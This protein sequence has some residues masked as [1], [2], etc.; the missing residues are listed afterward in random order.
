MFLV[1]EV[2][3]VTGGDDPSSGGKTMSEKAC[4][5]LTRNFN[6]ILSTFAIIK[7][8]ELWDCSGDLK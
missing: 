3:V 5:Q 1:S 6:I 8:V 4:N 7:L 2:E